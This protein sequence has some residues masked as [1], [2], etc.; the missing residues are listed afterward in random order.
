M[1]DSQLVLLT[2]AGTIV[3]LVAT[4]FL[5]R[6]AGR[7]GGVR[8][9]RGWDAYDAVQKLVVVFAVALILLLLVRL[10]GAPV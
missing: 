9:R 4:F 3:L 10:V 1:T 7:G 8:R 2:L 5:E 6:T